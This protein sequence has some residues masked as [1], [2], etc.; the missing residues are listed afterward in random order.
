M[1]LTNNLYFYPEQGMLDCNTYVIK[2]NASLV[3]DPGNAMFLPSLVDSMHKDGIDPKS[4]DLIANTHLH[5][6]HCGANEYFKQLS[7]AKITIHPLQKKYYSLV[8]VEAARVFGLPP[9]EF[10]ED[11]CLDNE[12]SMLLEEGV[13]HFCEFS[14]SINKT[15]QNT[16]ISPPVYG[17]REQEPLCRHEYFTDGIKI[18]I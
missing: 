2:G 15:R 12:S 9:M 17:R 1:K 4:I 8:V 13:G 7:A 16:G 11:T 3:I 6:D 10:K 18:I 14:Y 5:G